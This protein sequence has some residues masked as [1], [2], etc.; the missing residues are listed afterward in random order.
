M[1]V[2]RLTDSDV[3][4]VMEW[5]YEGRYSTYDIT[6]GISPGLGYYAVEDDRRLVGYCCFG[7]E[8]RVP[9]VAA[10]TGTLDVGYGLRPDLVGHGLS[11]QFIPA[12]LAF[13]IE[14][15]RPSRLRVLILRWN[16]RSR[17]AALANGFED[18][19]AHGDF[20]LLV[21]DT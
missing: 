13:G 7:A 10:E 5:R 19:G 12:V 11:R 21:R 1:K 15:Y 6:G 8:A 3:R 18:A 14:R 17:R 2:R 9:G 16:E 4:E 20:D